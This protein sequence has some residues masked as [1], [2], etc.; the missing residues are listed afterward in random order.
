MPKELLAKSS[1]F[2]H[3][4]CN[5]D[6][7]EKKTKTIDLHDTPF[8]IFSI[9][10]QW[11]YTGELVVSDEMAPATTDSDV[12]AHHAFYGVLYKIAIDLYIFADSMMDISLQ[13]QVMDLLQA[14][15]FSSEVSLGLEEAKQM[16]GETM[17]KCPLRRLLVDSVCAHAEGDWFEIFGNDLPVE[18][19]VELLAAFAAIRK[20]NKAAV[21]PTKAPKCTYHVH[22]EYHAACE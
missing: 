17:A 19:M 11:I 5:Q 8:E 18:I 14:T 20:S 22:D 21:C 3:S 10:L 4:A 9:Y 16:V 12:S 13:N 1:E 6:W 2:F 15:L 7:K